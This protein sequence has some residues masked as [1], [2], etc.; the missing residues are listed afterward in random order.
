MLISFIIPHMG[1]E[2]MLIQTLESITKQH[3]DLNSIEVI[4]VSKNSNASDE[5]LKFNQ[6]LNFQFIMVDESVTIAHQRNKG[7]HT[8]SG[9]YF[10]FVDADID[11]SEN[12]I[13]VML[14][15]LHNKQDVK[16]VSAAQKNSQNAN[17]LERVRTALVN[18]VMDCEV[19]FLR[20]CNLLM[21]RETFFKSKGFPEDLITCEDY[22]FSQRVSEFGKLYY[23]NETSYIHLGE[24]KAYFA[25]AKKEIWR[26]QSNFKSIE[27]RKVPFSEL[28]SFLVPPIFTCGVLLL[29]IGLWLNLNALSLVS[30]VISLLLLGSY[31]IRL[32]S[33]TQDNIPIKDIIFF[34]LL[35]FPARTIGTIKGIVT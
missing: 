11:L 27:G 23:T 5:L 24:D 7:A 30:I 31:T 1:R 14:A 8:A 4:V 9:E 13:N 17:A 25:M 2:E 15:I 26:G 33:S 34:Y 29:F 20:G 32:R 19:D 35:Y 12:W 16:L 28:P 6:S 18:T 21:R 3:F 22:A 10:A